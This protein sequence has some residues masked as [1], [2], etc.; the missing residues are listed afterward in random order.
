MEEKKMTIEYI[1]NNGTTKQR[2]DLLKSIYGSSYIMFASDIQ[3]NY[4]PYGVQCRLGRL[5]E[6]LNA[7]K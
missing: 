4:I 5:L 1:W 2:T 7:K 6:A 3:K